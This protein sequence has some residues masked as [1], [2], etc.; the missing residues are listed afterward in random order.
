MINLVQVVRG[1]KTLFGIDGEIH[2]VRPR[3]AFTEV[4]TVFP[5]SVASVKD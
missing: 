3:L 1:G 2:T 4:A 5:D